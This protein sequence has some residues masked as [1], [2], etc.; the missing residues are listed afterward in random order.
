MAIYRVVCKV[1]DKEQVRLI[2]APNTAAAMRFASGQWLT[3]QLCTTSEA[4]E[5]GA[6]GVK[7]E[8]AAP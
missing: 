1:Q 3:V 5:L 8:K 4:V 7:V 6:Q 2:D